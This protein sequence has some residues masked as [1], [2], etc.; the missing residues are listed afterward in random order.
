MRSHDGSGRLARHIERSRPVPLVHLD[1]RIRRARTHLQH[2]QLQQDADQLGFHRVV[3]QAQFSRPP[4]HVTR[5][6]FRVAQV[7]CVDMEP[8]TEARQQIGLQ[9]PSRLRVELTCPPRL[10]R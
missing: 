5:A 4:R 1:H 7:E 6:R 2:F 10:V 9:R 3:G 8:V